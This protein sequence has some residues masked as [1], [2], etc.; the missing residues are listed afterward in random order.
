[1]TLKLNN[2]LEYAIMLIMI[3]KE[4][5]QHLNHKLISKVQAMKKVALNLKV[6]NLTVRTQ[7][8]K[9]FLVNPKL[10]KLKKRYQVVKKKVLLKKAILKKTKTLPKQKNQKL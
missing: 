2:Q 5:N 10:K 7:A 8:A 3:Q 1:M 4:V 9:K 6:L